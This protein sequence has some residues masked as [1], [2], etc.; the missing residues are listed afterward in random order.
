MIAVVSKPFPIQQKETAGFAPLHLSFT[1]GRT[2]LRVLLCFLLLGSV[3]S[4]TAQT[5]RTEL[6]ERRKQLMADIEINSSRL[7]TIKKNKEAKLSQ[8]FALQTQIR[9][10]QQLVSTLQEELSYADAAILRVNDVM[11]ALQ[12]D[13]AHLKTEYAQMLR[14]AY[15][16]RLSGSFLTFLFSAENFNDAF[17]RWQYLQQYNRYRRRQ[18][19][20]IIE[21]Q[22][23]LEARASQLEEEK[24]EKEQLLLTAEQQ[25]KLLSRELGTMDTLIASLKKDESQVATLLKEQEKDHQRLNDM[26]EKI[27]FNEMARKRKEARQPAA[28]QAETGEEVAAMPVINAGDF[29]KS[30]GQLPWPVERGVITRHFGTQTHPTTKSVE[31]TNNGIDISTDAQTDILAIF[32]GEVVG[33]Q[34]VP[35]YKNTLILQHGPYYTVYS[36]MDEAYVKRGEVVNH[37]QPLG[38]MGDSDAELHFEIWREKQKLNPIHWI[39]R[40]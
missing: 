5:T 15:R 18:A 23:R 36:N 11:T 19:Q 29:A 16:H 4:L 26:I 32:A 1:T 6:E 9:K 34:Y 33:V 40:R 27:I 14:I 31:I 21:T 39:K 28:L 7:A 30:K 12:D 13:I 10:R 2:V 24:Q 3:F 17:R 22:E 25:Q 20:L 8:Y 38:R 35:G 37:G